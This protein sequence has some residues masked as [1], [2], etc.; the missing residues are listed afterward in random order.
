MNDKGAAVQSE[1]ALI[2]SRRIEGTPVYDPRGKKLGTIDTV[3]IDKSAG[4]VVFAVMSFGGLLGRHDD[5]YP[6]PWNMLAYDTARGGYVVDLDEA[7][8][9]S[10]PRYRTGDEPL[11]DPAYGEKI[12]FHY[13]GTYPFEIKMPDNLG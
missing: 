11:F 7:S 10:A 1:H 8:V 3:M 9:K 2:S 6:L 5:L 12:H 4:K 13:T